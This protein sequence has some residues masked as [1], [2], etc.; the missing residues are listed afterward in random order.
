MARPGPARSREVAS[1]RRIKLG[2]HTAFLC[3]GRQ[4]SPRSSW[5][6]GNAMMK[7]L[8]GSSRARS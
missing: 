5:L 8:I 7:F 4:Y 6:W 3:S 2:S 1:D